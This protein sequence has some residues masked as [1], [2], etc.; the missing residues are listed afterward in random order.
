MYARK[1]YKEARVR[2]ARPEELIVMLYDGALKALDKLTRAIGEK[3]PSDASDAV[4]SFLDITSY[5]HATID[6]APAPELAR[7]LSRTYEVWQGIIVRARLQ[8][9]LE[10]VE[11]IREQLVSLRDAWATAARTPPSNPD[12][13]PF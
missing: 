3:Q 10:T 11:E 12:Q 13:R 5:L 6:P 7:H 1:R 4:R 8:G 9:D 2:T